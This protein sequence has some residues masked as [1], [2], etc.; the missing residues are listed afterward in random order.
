MQEDFDRQKT[1]GSWALTYS[2]SKKAE[3]GPNGEN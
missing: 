1:D 3:F 2:R